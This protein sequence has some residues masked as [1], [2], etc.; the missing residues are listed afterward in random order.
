MNRRDFLRTALL[1][2]PALWTKF[3]LEPEKLEII[4][5]SQKFKTIGEI[6]LGE[7]WEPYKAG[8]EM[9][10]RVAEGY[11]EGVQQAPSSMVITVYDHTDWTDNWDDLPYETLKTVELEWQKAPV[12]RWSDRPVNLWGESL[13]KP[14]FEIEKLDATS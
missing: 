2:L 4:S 8:V 12:M 11:V 1:V 7:K 14:K 10:Q 6:A 5:D 13:L 9:G 3:Q